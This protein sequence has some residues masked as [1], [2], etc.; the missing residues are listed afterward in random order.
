MNECMNEISENDLR[1]SSSKLITLKPFLTETGVAISIP[2]F[3]AASFIY[4]AAS[5]ISRP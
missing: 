5:L 4:T 1:F 2:Y 3:T